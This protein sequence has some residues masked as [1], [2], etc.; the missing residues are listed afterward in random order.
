MRNGMSPSEAAA[1]AISRITK[2][3]ENF[4]GAILAVDK[5]GNHG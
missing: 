4:V 5:H 3:Y 1:D 2:Y